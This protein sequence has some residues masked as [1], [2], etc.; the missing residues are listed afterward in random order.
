MLSPPFQM[1]CDAIAVSIFRLPD[2]VISV[3]K[4]KLAQAAP[5]QEGKHISNED[6]HALM[7]HECVVN[8]QYEG[9]AA[10][11]VMTQHGSDG[12]RIKRIERCCYLSVGLNHWNLEVIAR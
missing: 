2:G 6:G 1:L 11:R 8:H 9:M 12:W 7:I 3:L 4:L 10:R 5:I